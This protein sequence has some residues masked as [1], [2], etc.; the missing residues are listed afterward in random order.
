MLKVPLPPL[1]EQQR[2][3][4]ILERADGLRRLRRYAL[5][6]SEGYLQAVFVE[7]FGDP[8]RNPKGWRWATAQ[9]SS[10]GCWTGSMCTPP[11]TAQLGIKLLYSPATSSGDL[12]DVRL[13]AGLH[14]RS[15]FAAKSRDM[16]PRTR[17]HHDACIPDSLA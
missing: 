17:R 8:V 9:M 14:P 13:Q 7:M 15:T 12:I 2:I 1:P 16:L 4:V 5:E 6:L 3:A 10:E 11:T